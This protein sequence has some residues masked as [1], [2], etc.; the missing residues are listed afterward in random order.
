MEKVDI[1][2]EPVREFLIQIAAFLPKLALALA[3]L[4]AGWLL[5]K[6]ARFA[7]TKALRAINFNVLTVNEL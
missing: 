3:V 7:I 6:F 4:I 1:M 2:L 5:A